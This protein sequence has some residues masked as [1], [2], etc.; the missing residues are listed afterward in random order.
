MTPHQT[1]HFQTNSV[2]IEG[3]RYIQKTP[4]NAEVNTI[5]PRPPGLEMVVKG[6]E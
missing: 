6:W 1:T 3:P 4:H 2:G 5:D